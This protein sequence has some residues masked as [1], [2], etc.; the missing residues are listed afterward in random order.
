[1]TQSSQPLP[2]YAV[3]EL[4]GKDIW[5]TEIE[6]RRKFSKE[7]LGMIDASYLFF[8]Y[9]VAGVRLPEVVGDTLNL[10]T[11]YQ[12]FHGVGMGVAV[13]SLMGPMRVFVGIGESGRFRWIISIGPD[14]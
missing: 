4:Y 13:S 11:P 14:F 9:G 7:M 6:F 3:D 2:G 8:K 10:N 1:M 5:R 12:F